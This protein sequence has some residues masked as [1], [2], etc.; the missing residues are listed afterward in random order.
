MFL[1]QTYVSHE[2]VVVNGLSSYVHYGRGQILI[3]LSFP[4][5]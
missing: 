5:G 2:Q 4:V 1:P 3:L